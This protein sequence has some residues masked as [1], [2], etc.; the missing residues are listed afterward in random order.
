M[1]DAIDFLIEK[2]NKRIEHATQLKNKITH[3]HQPTEEEVMTFYHSKEWQSVRIDILKR[4][5]GNDQVELRERHRI[6]K[7]NTVH[8]I[9]PLR[10]YWELRAEPD[11]LEVVSPANH[12]VEHPEKGMRIADRKTFKQKQERIN[13]EEKQGVVVK[14]KANI[15]LD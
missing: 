1:S 12:N 10:D 14:S 15:E 13:K 9:Y 8:H 3:F 4:D 5:Y 2:S 6:K 7:G 11:N